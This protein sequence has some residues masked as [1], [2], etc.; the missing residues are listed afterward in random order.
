V[1]HLT[2]L[3]NGKRLVSRIS[4]VEGLHEGQT[5][6]RDIIDPV[7]TRARLDRPT[8]APVDDVGVALDLRRAGE[9]VREAR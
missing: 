8:E 6:L 5:V 1:V 3:Q 7:R 2:R 4:S 9:L